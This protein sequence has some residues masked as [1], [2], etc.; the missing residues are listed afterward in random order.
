MKR[1]CNDQGRTRLWE[2]LLSRQKFPCSVCDVPYRSDAL[3]RHYFTMVVMEED[4]NPLDP[5][6][7]RFESLDKNKQQ[8]TRYFFENSYNT[9]EFPPLKAP[10]VERGLQSVAKFFKTGPSVE[11]REER[12]EDNVEV[13]EVEEQEL[14]GDVPGTS[15]AASNQP[16]HPHRSFSDLGGGDDDV[17][18]PGPS[19][20]RSTQPPTLRPTVIDIDDP[21]DSQDDWSDLS[22]R[23]H[24]LRGDCEVELED[25][26]DDPEECASSVVSGL[27]EEHVDITPQEGRGEDGEDESETGRNDYF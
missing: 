16:P 20:G 6:S 15:G 21:T 25:N 19:R 7:C 10:I 14:E 22:R 2:K 27:D 4:G 26:P 17:I 5:K 12:R 24:V 18:V 13:V 3:Y 8:H 23:I 11:E 9:G 1:S